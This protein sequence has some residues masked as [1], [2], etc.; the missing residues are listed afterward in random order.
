VKQHVWQLF[1]AIVGGLS[2]FWIKWPLDWVPV[3]TLQALG[4]N[5][6]YKAQMVESFVVSAM[7]G[8]GL[9]RVLRW[10][11]RLLAIIAIPVFFM[12]WFPL[13]VTRQARQ[14]GFGPEY[15]FATYFVNHLQFFAPSVVGALVGASLVWLIATKNGYVPPNKPLDR[16]RPR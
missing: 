8:A 4:A 5:G 16:S 9:M 10:R 2:M 7:I 14:L 11:Y 12:V 3:E 15:N 1:L 13:Q 6:L